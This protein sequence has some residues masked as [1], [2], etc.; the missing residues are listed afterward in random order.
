MA[1]RRKYW[2]QLQASKGEA[3]LAVDLHNRSGNERWLEAFIVHMALAWLKLLQAH[4]EESGKSR[5]LYLLDD[6]KRRQ[7]TREG[8]WLMKPL[9]TLL[10]ETYVDVSAA[11]KNVEFFLGLRHKIE[12]R[13]D[14]DVAALVSGRVQAIVLNFEREL[15]R[16]FG[17]EEGLAD[18]LRFPVFVGTVTDD[19]LEALKVVRARTA[20]P[21]LD[22]I[23]DFDAA[24]DPEVAADSAYDFRVVLIPQTGP[25]TEADVA[26]SFVRLEEL[27]DEQRVQIDKALTIIREKQVP[28]QDYDSLRPAQVAERVSEQIGIRFNTHDHTSCWQHY[29]VRPPRDS[30]HPERTKPEFCRWN[31]TFERHVFTQ[32]WVAYLVRKLGDADEHRRVLGR[33]PEALPQAP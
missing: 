20:R 9:H 1:A 13:H 27:D 12:H 19:A 29:E 8:D 22:Y 33:D 24:L 18:E 11:R 25:K 7:R 5:A 15:V 30:Q 4:Y 17:P 6:Q 2:H 14:R 32:A 31:Q 16:M 3:R 10:A 21:V 26:M 28:V 23:Q